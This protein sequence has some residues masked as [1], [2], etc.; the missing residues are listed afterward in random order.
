MTETASGE[1]FSFKL[2]KSLEQLQKLELEPETMKLTTTMKKAEIKIN[3]KQL[4]SIRY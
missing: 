4:L 1:N 3:K 2:L